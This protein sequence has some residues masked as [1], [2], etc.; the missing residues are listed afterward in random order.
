MYQNMDRPLLCAVLW[1]AL[2]LVLVVLV[3]VTRRLL[4]LPAVTPTAAVGIAWLIWC[5]GIVG[6]LG[7]VAA[8]AYRDR[9]TS[10]WP[11]PG[12]G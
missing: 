1:V 5:A 3:G 7:L 12:Q 11:S 10:R 2:L 4:D 6:W 9:T 8:S